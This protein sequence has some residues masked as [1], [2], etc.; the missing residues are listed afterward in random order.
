MERTEKDN[1]GRTN[2][3]FLFIYLHQKQT[4]TPNGKDSFAQQGLVA[5]LDFNL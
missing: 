3:H 2:T 5:S 1:E 4:N